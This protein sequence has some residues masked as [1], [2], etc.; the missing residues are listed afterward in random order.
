VQVAE[1]QSRMMPATRL[2]LYVASATHLQAMLHDLLLLHAHQ[3]RMR[4]MT[5]RSIHAGFVLH[6]CDAGRVGQGR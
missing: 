2:H 4:N 3:Q 6:C 1:L 5:Q